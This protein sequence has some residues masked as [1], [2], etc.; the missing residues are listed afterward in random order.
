MTCSAAQWICGAD[1]ACATA[2]EYYQRFCGALFRGRACT[3][4]CR[5]SV[6]ILRRQAAAR[7]LETCRCEDEGCQVIKDLTEELCYPKEV[8]DNE[9]ATNEI[10]GSSGSASS[11]P[12]MSLIALVG[13]CLSTL[14]ASR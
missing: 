3:P 9:V 1:P 13:L 5:N 6:D 2:F 8:E 7:K 14:G 10:E 4:R 12:A 11:L